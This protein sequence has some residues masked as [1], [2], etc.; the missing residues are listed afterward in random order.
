[1]APCGSTDITCVVYY[2][3]RLRIVIRHFW[4]LLFSG[5]SSNNGASGLSLFLYQAASEVKNHLLAS[6]AALS[7]VKQVPNSVKKILL[8]QNGTYYFI[9]QNFVFWDI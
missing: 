1:M 2:R 6:K 9:V 3:M 8:H 4:W 5:F 7:S